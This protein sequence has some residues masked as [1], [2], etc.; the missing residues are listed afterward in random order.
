M[1]QHTRQSV[2]EL[3]ASQVESDL[4]DI[5]LEALHKFNRKPITTRIADHMNSLEP[6]IGGERWRLVRHYGW[7]S[8]ETD[9]YRRTDTKQG[10][11]LMLARTE[12]SVPLDLAWVEKENG[13]YFDARRVR[14]LARTEILNT[15]YR[16]DKISA[17]MNETESAIHALRAAVVDLEFAC[18]AADIY[19]VKRA[20]GLAD[21]DSRPLLNPQFKVRDK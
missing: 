2:Y 7:T 10:I 17:T 1:T 11:S 13:A 16:L 18:Y 14:N 3:I 20:C 4:P 12:S 8:L 21:A 9:S 5:V 15:P 6:S 19:A